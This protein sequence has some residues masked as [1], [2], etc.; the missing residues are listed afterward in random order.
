MQLADVLGRT[1]PN[2][3]RVLSLC[4]SLSIRFHHAKVNR[5]LKLCHP[6]CPGL[7]WN[8]SGGTCGL[9]RWRNE[10]RGHSLKH[11]FAVSTLWAALFVICGE[12]KE[13]A[14]AYYHSA[15]NYSTLG[16]GDVIMSPS[17]KLLG[18]LEAADGALMF[19]V[20]TAMIFSVIQ[21][22]ILARYTDLRAQ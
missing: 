20:S 21:R 2:E 15:V 12:F 5:H 3:I 13:F 16:Y 17:W 6:A 18:P 1:R 22:L 10:T 7:P 14:V 9:R 11:S 8:R 4:L 19:G